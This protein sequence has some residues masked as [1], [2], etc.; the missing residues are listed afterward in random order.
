MS[1]TKQEVMDEIKLKLLD[2][3]DL[4]EEHKK[5]I[6]NSAIQQTIDTTLNK[7]FGGINDKKTTNPVVAQ[8][9]AFKTIVHKKPNQPIKKNNQPVVVEDKPEKP[10]ATDENPLGLTGV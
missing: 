8:R 2:I 1:M 7:W 4:C 10:E 6:A 5:E 9:R 3:H